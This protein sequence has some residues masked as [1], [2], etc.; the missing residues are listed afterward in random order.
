MANKYYDP[1]G[2]PQTGAPGSSAAMRSELATI[3]TGFE[4]V[5]QDIDDALT[6]ASGAVTTATA[7]AGIATTQ[8][9]ISTTQAGIATT[10]AG[11]STTQAGIA[12]TQAGIAADKAAEAAA[13]KLAV[14]ATYDEF[15]DRYLG[16]KASDPTTDND[17]GALQEGTLY[18]NTTTKTFK[19]YNGTAWINL[20]A[21][22]AASLTFSPTGNISSTN[23]QAA[24]AEL[25]SEKLSAGA[26]VVG[27]TNLADSSVSTAK[28]TDTVFSELT[29]ATI[30]ADDYIAIADTSAAGAKRRG[31]VS[32]L[33]TL[34]PPGFSAGT[35]MPFNQTSAPTGWTKDTTAALNDSIMRIVTGTVASGGAT[36][37][38]TFNG[39]TSVGATTLA[40]AQMPSHTHTWQNFTGVSGSQIAAGQ[41]GITAGITATTSAQGGGDSHSHSLT[42]DIKY[43]DFIIAVKD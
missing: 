3:A 35:R 10:Q 19:G 9:G 13:T 25:D 39:Q 32:D 41:A 11:I 20:P 43:F 42:T 23:V 27:E 15:D 37:F 7:Q 40:I 1:S 14:D 29:S 22:S 24:I 4:G 8:A 12:T 38:T 16:R 18:F 30:A 21:T 34:V 28:L 6:G 17:G 5:E 2:Y 26:G 36:A 33:L 31:L